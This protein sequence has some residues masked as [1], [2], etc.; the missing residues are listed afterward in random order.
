MCNIQWWD[1]YVD[2]FGHVMC[3]MSYV[4]V[5]KSFFTSHI[6]QTCFDLFVHHQ[7]F[8][9]GWRWKCRASVF[10]VSV[11]IMWS[12]LCVRILY[13]GGPSFLL[14]CVCY[15]WIKLE[16]FRTVHF[17][18]SE[19]RMLRISVHMRAPCRASV[20]SLLRDCISFLVETEFICVWSLLIVD[21]P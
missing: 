2:W 13:S 10:I 19:T 4:K 1:I 21:C 11:F 8:K 15:E 12:L 7:A 5:F 18:I 20:I 16:L 14:H 9:N 6:R 17:L 3:S